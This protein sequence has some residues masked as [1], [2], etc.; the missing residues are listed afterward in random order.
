V[1]GGGGVDI[2]GAV[3]PAGRV[4]FSFD[5]TG[6]GPVQPDKQVTAKTIQQQKKIKN[7]IQ[8][9]Y[10]TTV[11]IFCFRDDQRNNVRFTQ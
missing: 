10:P 6:S 3:V 2:A 1:T 8:G 4:W 11:K 5:R 9:I 7:F